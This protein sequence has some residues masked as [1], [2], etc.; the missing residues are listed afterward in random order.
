MKKKVFLGLALMAMLAGAANA[1]TTFTLKLGG[2]FPQDDF[3]QGDEDRWGLMIDNSKKG[4]AGTGFTLGGEWVAPISNINGLGLS[5]T[6]DAIYNGLNSDIN[7]LFDDLNL[8]YEDE[9]DEFSM[10]TPKYI[11]IPVMLGLRYSFDLNNGLAI[12]ADGGLGANLRIITPF[13]MHMEEKYDGGRAETD[14]T[15]TFNSAV[16]FAFRVGAGITINQKYSLGVDYYAL[17]ASKVKG[18]EVTESY[19]NGERDREKEDFKGGKIAPALL[20]LRLGIA[21]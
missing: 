10:S 8:D 17:G 1:Q 9:V 11:N 3:G 4:G 7:E 21:L 13:N 12:F 18:E 20:M 6:I 16:S 5:V 19:Y 14:M 2:A 15:M